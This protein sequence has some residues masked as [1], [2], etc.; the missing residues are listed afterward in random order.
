[1]KKIGCWMWLCL[2][3]WVSCMPLWAQQESARE[4]LDRTAEAIRSAGG[5]KVLF[6][7]QT[8]DGDRQTGCI[9]L[10][11]DRFRLEA[12]GIITWFD[13]HTQWTYLP[14]S[15]EVNVSE[16]SPEE[17]QTLNPYAWLSLYNKGYKLKLGKVDNP[18][19]SGCHKVV[20]TAED[21][22]QELQCIILYVSK[23]NG[24]PARI[25]MAQ[26]GGGTALI[27]IDSFEGGQTYTEGDFRFEPKEYPMAEVVDL[28]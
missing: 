19:F 10:Q 26:R 8:S 3:L 7:V 2:L 17:L 9:R 16:P 14:S 6:T 5:V 27:V 12:G 25:S 24:R 4:I 28:R 15:E 18:A 22:Q 23:E 13:G 20:L 21:R 11:G 1:M